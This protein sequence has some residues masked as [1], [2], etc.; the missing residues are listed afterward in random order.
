MS[1]LSTVCEV[2]VHD[3]LDKPVLN[4]VDKVAVNWNGVGVQQLHQRVVLGNVVLGPFLKVGDLQE[5]GLL[6]CKV[7]PHQLLQGVVQPSIVGL[8]HN[9]SDGIKQAL[10]LVVQPVV[11]NLETGVPDV[12]PWNLMS[13]CVELALVVEVC[14]DDV[15]DQPVGGPLKVLL[16]NGHLDGIQLL[17]EGVVFVVVLLAVIVGLG[18]AEQPALVIEVRS[19]L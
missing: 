19:H 3:V 2:S 11:E 10:V 1:H 17:E 14:V 6:V 18:V 12:G 13:V 7:V 4:V 8:V 9:V 5:L 15:L 16:G